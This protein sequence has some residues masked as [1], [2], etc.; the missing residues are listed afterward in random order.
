MPGMNKKKQA[1][2]RRPSG[3]IQSQVQKA[4]NEDNLTHL[5][6]KYSHASQHEDLSTN[7]LKKKT[8]KKNKNKNKWI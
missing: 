3:L 5:L 1:T 7:N 6:A 2:K 4:D 8:T